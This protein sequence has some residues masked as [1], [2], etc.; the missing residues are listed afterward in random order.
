MREIEARFNESEEA[1]KEDAA[2]RVEVRRMNVGFDDARPSEA[3]L[4]IFDCSVNKSSG[5]DC[6]GWE[7]DVEFGPASAAEGLAR[8]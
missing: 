2:R 4:R 3:E 1:E 7:G 8:A 5:F 6:A